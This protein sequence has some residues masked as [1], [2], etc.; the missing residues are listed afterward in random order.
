MVE[1]KRFV[2]IQMRNA[3]DRSNG[4]SQASEG[5]IANYTDSTA[6]RK[7]LDAHQMGNASRSS[8][9]GMVR[10]TFL[11]SYNKHTFRIRKKQA[12]EQFLCALPIPCYRRSIPNPL[13]TLDTS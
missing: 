11:P 5:T 1:T 6:C 12:K 13:F 8:P 3:I 10:T 2:N 4:P 9:I 7:Y